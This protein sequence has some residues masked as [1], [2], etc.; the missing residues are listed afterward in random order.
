MTEI[1]KRIP[2]DRRKKPT[3]A[4]SW[5][6]F[7]GRRRGFRR[8]LDKEKGGYVDRYSSKLFFFLILMIGLNIL[9]VLF[10]MMILDNKGWEFNPIVRS[11]MNIHGDG[12]WIWKFT[13]VSISLTLL[14]LHSKFR[15][16]KQII[17]GLSLI[18]LLIILYQLFVFFRL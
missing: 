17:I 11:V 15:H 1:D 12:F 10:T 16:V 2:Q 13:I 3:P 14:C 5:Y 18:Y 6:T 4:L 8:E 9:D 7:F